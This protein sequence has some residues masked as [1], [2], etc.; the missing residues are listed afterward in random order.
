[1]AWSRH[2]ENF[3]AARSPKRTIMTSLP[4][5]CRTSMARTRLLKLHCPI[6]K[7]LVSIKHEEFP[8]CSPRCRSLDLG[9]WASGAYAISSPV[10]DTD[11]GVADRS[12]E[13]DD[14]S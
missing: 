1:M 13:S 14:E 6:C 2:R 8:F 5:S 12:G 4:G 10:Q 7:K 3:I 11:E 9:K